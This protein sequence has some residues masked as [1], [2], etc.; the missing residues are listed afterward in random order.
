MH[1]RQLETYNLGLLKIPK[2]I[3]QKNVPFQYFRSIFIEKNVQSPR[4]RQEGDKNGYKRN[5]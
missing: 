5:N 2:A 1:M 4:L 3:S